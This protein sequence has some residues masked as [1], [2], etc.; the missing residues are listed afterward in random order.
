LPLD[1]ALSSYLDSARGESL[2]L[3]IRCFHAAA[4]LM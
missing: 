4:L 1:L 2:D 3:E